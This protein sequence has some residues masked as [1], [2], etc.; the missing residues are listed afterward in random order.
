MLIFEPGG[1]QTG[2]GYGAGLLGMPENGHAFYC[3]KKS[4]EG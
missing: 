4:E 1:Q 3:G 2:E